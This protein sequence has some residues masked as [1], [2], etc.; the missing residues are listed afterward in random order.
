MFK[1]KASTPV[2]NRNASEN[3]SFFESLSTPT[4]RRVSFELS[5]AETSTETF[6]R[7]KTKAWRRKKVFR[8]ASPGS[9]ILGEI[10]FMVQVQEDNSLVESNT[11]ICLLIKGEDEKIELLLELSSSKEQRK[12][13]NIESPNDFPWKSISDLCSRYYSWILEDCDGLTRGI[14]NIRIAVLADKMP[15]PKAKSVVELFTQK[16]LPY[17]DEDV[18]KN[19]D[20]VE[21]LFKETQALQKENLTLPDINAQHDML[22]PILRGY[23]ANAVKWML[24]REKST[25]QPQNMDWINGLVEIFKSLCGNMVYYN[26]YSQLLFLETPSCPPFPRGGILA[27]EMGL[28]KTVAVIALILN[29]H[30]DL[31]DK[32]DTDEFLLPIASDDVKVK[33]VSSKKS[34]HNDC[35]LK[36]KNQENYLTPHEQLILTTR[37]EPLKPALNKWYES[38]LAEYSAATPKKKRKVESSIKC[39]CGDTSKRDDMLV[40][41]PECEKE[42]HVNCVGFKENYRYFCPPCWTKQKLVLSNATL[43]ISPNSIYQQWLEEFKKHVKPEALPNE[44]F[45]Y[46]SIKG[47][48]IQPSVL[49]SYDV[50]ITTYSRLRAELYHAIPN[51]SSRK[52]RNEERFLKQCS[53][54]AQIDWWRLCLDEAQMVENDCS[55]INHM[56]KMI[57]AVNRWSV[58]GTPI[59][60][61]VNDIFHLMDFLR[62]EPFTDK[63]MWNSVLYLP[64]IH[65]EKLPLCSTL[66]QIFWRNSKQDVSDEL[67]I[68]EQKVRYHFLKFTAVEQNFYMREHNISS[69]E[70]AESLRKSGLDFTRT[71][72]SLNKAVLT[73]LLNPLLNL[74]QAC[75]HPLAVKGNKISTKTG[76]MT[77]TELFKYLYGKTKIECEEELRK[78]IAAL[79]GVA[80]IFCIEEDWY[81]AVEYYRRVLQIAEEYNEK[82]HVDSLQR[83]H[84]LTNLAEVLHFSGDNVPRTLRDDSLTEQAKQLEDKYMQ[85]AIG[86]LKSDQKSMEEF[87]AKITEL[88]GKFYTDSDVWWVRIIH[89]L[90]VEN[91]IEEVMDKVSAELLANP[92]ENKKT[93]EIFLSK[94]SSP[95]GIEFFLRNW[96]KSIKDNRT[97][98]L[99]HLQKLSETSCSDLVYQAVDCHLRTTTSALKKKKCE[100]CICENVLLDYECCL[101][102]VSRKIL[103]EEYE[104]VMDGAQT[105]GSWKAHNAEKVLKTLLSVGKNKA[106]SVK[107]PLKD[108]KN[109]LILLDTMKK[110][111]KQLRVVWMSLNHEV[112]ARDE[113]SMCKLRLRLRYPGEPIPPKQTKLNLK[114]QNKVEMIYI[115]EDHEVEPQRMKLMGEIEVS[116]SEFK[117]KYGTLLYL[118]NLGKKENAKPEPCPI[119]KMT[120]ENEWCVL[121]CGHS[122][123]IDCIRILLMRNCK[124]SIS[125]PVCRE[126]T[127]SSDLSFIDLSGR[128]ENCDIKVVGE[129]STKV[130]AVVR[131]LLELKNQDEKVKVLIFST[132]AVVLNVLVVALEENGI[133][134]RRMPGRNY[135]VHLKQF[136]D[137]KLNITALLL[138]I[139]WGSKGLNLIEAT[140]V[141]LVEPIMNPAEELQALGRVHRI[142]QN[143]E[144]VVH[145]FLIRRTIEEKIHA[146][147]SEA[148]DKWDKKKVTLEDLKNLFD[149]K[150]T[151]V[152]SNE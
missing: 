113:V 52:L 46:D 53:P 138:P 123:C 91:A 145:R 152:K 37:K 83:I 147:V 6:D 135:Q 21:I 63:L 114:E 14:V 2:R 142:G 117:K 90:T 3:F 137:P 27:D 68:P 59:Q 108:G 29:H 131:T 73:R 7:S 11:Q 28:G 74:R 136:K 58:T 38:A 34:F 43:I 122:Y 115:I 95:R 139:A 65:G 25:L 76:S 8:E 105:K 54:L 24:M 132:W 119:C 48:F 106:S 121:Q 36:R 120:L 92:T 79:N 102:A 100:L 82:V 18:E 116:K 112:Q 32:M 93:V 67:H 40:K 118:D 39:V 110:E 71:I 80:G 62:L 55:N 127:R 104:K 130:E 140:H 128:E 31:T 96:L 41:C 51:E 81:N 35:E 19:V 22:R 10:S 12:Y 1:R 66:S 75:S 44:I 56:A 85:K 4:E 94:I 98:V 5:E 103:K 49:A 109:H 72:D 129:H 47:N 23:Q 16:D 99:K 111:F 149:I 69:N 97:K 133:S 61:S 30:R 20:S 150:S 17:Y 15:I 13:Y 84:T 50:V 151:L 148:K 78:Y 86:D 87:A 33:P 134:F 107:W 101:F 42:Q 45:M 89:D 88:E 26:K 141:F 144:T 60:K 124:P 125:C 9:I 64:Y 146:T 77:M 57:S 70:F 126:L 143:N